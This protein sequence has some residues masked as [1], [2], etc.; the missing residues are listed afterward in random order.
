MELKAS[1]KKRSDKTL[2]GC[3]GRWGAKLR[4]RSRRMR[5]V[6]GEVLSKYSI[7]RRWW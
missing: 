4:V 6:E 7:E 1:W 2:E 3:R 5:S